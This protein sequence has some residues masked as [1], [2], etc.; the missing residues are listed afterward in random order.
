[1]L[2]SITLLK[3]HPIQESAAPKVAAAEAAA[4]DGVAAAK[5]GHEEAP[6]ESVIASEGD[7][8]EC[9]ETDECCSLRCKPSVRYISL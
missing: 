2:L 4:A 7:S 9:N 5:F 1:M 8:S 6:E 3:L